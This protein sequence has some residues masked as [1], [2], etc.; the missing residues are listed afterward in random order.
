MAQSAPLLT[1]QPTVAEVTLGSVVA[2]DGCYGVVWHATRDA[3]RILPIRRGPGS[4][5]LS[6]ANEVALHLPT[7]WPGWSIVCNELIT[8]PRPSCT[9]VGELDERCLLKALE[10]RKKATLAASSVISY[11]RMAAATHDAARH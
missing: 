8:W 5:P 1:N 10:T 2:W 7:D 11:Q 9:I 6:L 4:L 3:L